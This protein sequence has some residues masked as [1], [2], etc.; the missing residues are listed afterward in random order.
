M[1]TQTEL[2]TQT[3]HGGARNGA[4][5]KPKAA[6]APDIVAQLE[7]ERGELTRETSALEL[8]EAELLP[9]LKRHQSGLIAGDADA[10]AAAAGAT[11]RLSA[12]R[13]RRAEIVVRLPLLD[14][15]LEAANS[16]AN[17]AH[18]INELRELASKSAQTLAQLE[19]DRARINE[20]LIEVAPR[21]KSA[22]AGMNE[23]RAN[24][25]R[26]V[27]DLSPLVARMDNPNTTLENWEAAQPKLENLLGQFAQLE[28]SGVDLRALRYDKSGRYSRSFDVPLE[29][30]PL[31]FSDVIAAIEGGAAQPAPMPTAEERNP[32]A[33]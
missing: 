6:T 15:E 22:R 18:L 27:D 4:G 5:R 23:N 16:A 19:G 14:T 32:F 12:A 29:L 1:T 30:Q 11:A 10:V 20:M 2:E 25:L 31:E 3:S 28:N 26:I 33:R 7:L 9:E 13:D 17:E 21:L 8:L 24:F